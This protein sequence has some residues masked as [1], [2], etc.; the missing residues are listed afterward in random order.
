MTTEHATRGDESELPETDPPELSASTAP[1][2][3]HHH[4]FNRLWLG[5]SVSAVGSQLTTLALPLT[6][7]AYLNATSTQVGIMT[8]I[9]QL[10][11]VAPALFFGV[12]VD[13]A[14]KRSL[15]I[16]SDIGRAALLTAVPIL[17][18]TNLL[19]M[20]A[21]YVAAFVLGCLTVLFDLAYRAY[22]PALIGPEALL[23]GNSRLQSTDSISY[24]VGPGLGGI[25][26]QLLRAPFALLVDAGSFVF[27]TV[28]LL[29]IK[30]REPAPERE[31]GAGVRGVFSQIR[32]GIAF[33]FDQPIL[34]ALV[35][36]SATFNFFSQ[37]QLTVF[38]VYAARVMHMPSGQIG[39]VYAGFG[40]GGI[41]VAAVLPRL[42]RLLGYGP[43]LLC[44]CM[45]AIVG[46]TSLPLVTGPLHTAWFVMGYL[47][48]GSGIVAVTIVS[49][50]LRQAL[51]PQ[52]MQGRVMASYKV[53]IGSL[54]PVSAVLAGFLG[55]AIGLRATLFVCAGGA[56]IAIVWLVFSPVLS[57]RTL[58]KAA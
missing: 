35:L 13:Q 26:V 30:A 38:V 16:G 47:V 22:L 36:C 43:L 45:A 58:P 39:L 54:M 34:R 44:G 53:V 6:A 12:L 19:A 27:S 1:S 42:M 17:A 33:A 14:R 10:A 51:T 46:V 4:D 31:R 25:L 41:L 2:L 7:V 15:M 29:L 24:V 55:D 8:G 5:Q 11:L 9:L 50:T 37:I 18:A 49:M 32:S 23:S 40:V 48:A 52:H 56:P 20:P 57:V 28:S 21:M 3:R